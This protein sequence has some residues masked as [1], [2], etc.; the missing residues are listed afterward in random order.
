MTNPLTHL[1]DMPVATFLRDYW[2]KKPLL[3]R[4]AFPNFE[5]PVSADELAGLAME[6]GVES[7]LIS[8]SNDG[9]HWQLQHGPFSEEELTEL[10]PSD[11][12]LLVQAVDHWVPEVAE[13]LSHFHFLPSWRMD[14]LMISYASDGGGVGPHYDNYD[15]FLLQASGTRRWEVGGIYDETSPRREDTPVMILPEWQPEATWDLKPGDMLYIP[16][17]VG[18]NGYAVGNECMTYSIGFRA[19]SHEEVLDGFAEFIGQQLLSEQRYS[20][21]DITATTN[22]AEIDAAAIT[23]VQ[24]IL[25]HYVNEP[26]QVAEWFGRFMT[27]PKYPDQLEA[28][29]TAG[30]E[31]IETLLAEGIPCHRTE[32]SRF[33]YLQQDG[34]YKLFVDGNSFSCADSQAELISLLCSAEQVNPEVTTENLNLLLA[35]YRQGSLYFSE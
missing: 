2:Q 35:L 10:P 9:K 5:P 4:N 25:Q 22:A 29:D 14:D 3:I 16:P 6:E 8:Q 34:G 33:A 32:G 13:L 31:E 11:W 15:V 20:D 24:A 21:P 28:D 7:R 23:R 12:T 26:S 19:P 18:H 1:G 27:E 17:R 30:L